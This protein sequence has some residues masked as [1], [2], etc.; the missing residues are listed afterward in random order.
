[1]AY[2]FAGVGR[3]VVIVGIVTWVDIVTRGEETI[4]VTVIMVVCSEV[5]IVFVYV[6]AKIR[7]ALCAVDTLPPL[8]TKASD[9][10]AEKGIAGGAEI[11]GP[12]DVVAEA[13]ST[14]EVLEKVTGGGV[15][16]YVD[17]VV[18]A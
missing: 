6:P 15:D 3:V 18:D 17:A 14:F 8:E 9:D 11:D 7:I 13:R 10:E 16:G 4:L 5:G 12:V 2:G 1:M